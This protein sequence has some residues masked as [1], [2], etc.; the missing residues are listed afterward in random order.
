[1]AVAGNDTCPV[2]GTLLNGFGSFTFCNACD[3][4]KVTTTAPAPIKTSGVEA[5]NEAQYRKDNFPAV[6]TLPSSGSIP[7]YY[8][9]LGYLGGEEDPDDD[10]DDDNEIIP[11][12]PKHQIKTFG[13]LV[14]PSQLSIQQRGYVDLVAGTT[15]ELNEPKNVLAAIYRVRLS[16]VNTIPHIKG[17]L[18]VLNDTKSVFLEQILYHRSGRVTVGNVDVGAWDCPDP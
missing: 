7:Y 2:H 8:S 10:D 4:A 11:I 16:E 12:K 15:I 13:W 17:Q 9:P 1:M 5:Y 6:A 3:A 14:V 18:R